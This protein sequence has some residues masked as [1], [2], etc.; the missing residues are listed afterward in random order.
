MKER[1]KEQIDFHKFIEEIKKEVRDEIIRSVN[2]KIDN[3]SK[4]FDLHKNEMKP[5]LDLYKTTNNLSKMI[6][7]F[8]KIILALGI[9][10]GGT[11]TFFKYIK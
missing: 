2:G 11:I 10:V 6:I 9:I 5:I 3:L 1:R 4:N 8:S 7:W